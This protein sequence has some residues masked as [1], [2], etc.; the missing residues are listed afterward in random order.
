VELYC[1]TTLF[2][3]AALP[4]ATLLHRL[5]AFNGKLTIAL[6]HQ[7]SWRVPPAVSRKRLSARSRKLP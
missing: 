4:R 1:A 2:P 3:V 6:P 5:F 7:R